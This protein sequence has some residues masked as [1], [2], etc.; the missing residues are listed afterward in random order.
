MKKTIIK[1]ICMTLIVQSVLAPISA[2]RVEAKV[3]N[4]QKTLQSVKSNFSK[5]EAR[6]WNFYDSK[7]KK[8]TAEEALEKSRGQF[9]VEPHEK[10][11]QSDLVLNAKATMQSQTGGIAIRL[12]AYHG[13]S[14]GQSI[15]E[16]ILKIDPQLSDLENK[17]N[18]DRSLQFFQWE[19]EQR[20]SSVES[21]RTSSIASFFNSIFPSA[22][23]DTAGMFL[24]IQFVKMVS[25]VA[26]I[27]AVAGVGVI[28]FCTIAGLGNI[29][30]GM[31]SNSLWMGVAKGAAILA[32]SAT[33]YKLL[34]AF[35]DHLTRLEFNDE[36]KE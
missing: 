23:A 34:D 21:K 12:S 1:F 30:A 35:A 22:Q 19:I 31:E 16:T 15:A 28:L 18:L 6:G 14:T 8:L 5:L 24:F 26:V 11:I 36:P 7:K 25:L 3:V 27:G 29:S 9:Y 17:V 4:D 32:V 10:G 13:W 2:K 20:F 33:V